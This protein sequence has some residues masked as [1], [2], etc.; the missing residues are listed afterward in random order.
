MRNKI[1]ASLTKKQ[2]S[3][4]NEDVV[5]IPLHSLE[6]IMQKLISFTNTLLK[7]YEKKIKNI[8]LKSINFSGS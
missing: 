5:V 1:T 6:K 7:N 8:I 3:Q 4:E 2:I